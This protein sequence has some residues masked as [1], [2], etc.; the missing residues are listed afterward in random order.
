MEYAIA[1]LRENLTS[2]SARMSCYRVVIQQDGRDIGTL[3][4]NGPLEETQYLARQIA[5]KIDADAFRISDLTDAEVGSEKR[6]FQ[7]QGHEKSE[8]EAQIEMTVS[9]LW[10]TP[11][12][13]ERG[14]R[15]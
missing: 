6:P 8:P 12:L 15:P 9:P 10:Q 2:A 5:I 13:L 7:D 14:K 1:R 4:W 11:G 3:Y